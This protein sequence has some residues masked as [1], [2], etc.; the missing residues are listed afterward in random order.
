[1]EMLLED[2]ELN[3]AGTNTYAGSCVV[4]YSDHKM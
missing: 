2:C 1:V 3:R 4:K